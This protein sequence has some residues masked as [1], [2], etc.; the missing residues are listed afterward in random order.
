MHINFNELC[1]KEDYRKMTQELKDTL[2][3][4]TPHKLTESSLEEMIDCYNAIKQEGTIL[5]VYATFQYYFDIN[6]KI[7]QRQCWRQIT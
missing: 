6:N 2:S 5:Q 3:K 7:S 1:K 4:I